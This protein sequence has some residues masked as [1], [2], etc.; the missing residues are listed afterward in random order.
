MEK[1]KIKVSIIISV[2][3]ALHFTIQPGCLWRDFERNENIQYQSRYFLWWASFWRPFLRSSGRRAWC[4]PAGEAAPDR[5]TPLTSLH[6][7]SAAGWYPGQNPLLAWVGAPPGPH[8]TLPPLPPLPA[9]AE[10]ELGWA[11]LRFLCSPFP[12][13]PNSQP[14]GW[15]VLVITERLTEAAGQPRCAKNQ[16]SPPC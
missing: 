1:F 13:T 7:G 8:R 2:Q 5:I 14:L 11:G 16:C 9:A 15:T 4:I 12:T 10:P 3:T 6:P